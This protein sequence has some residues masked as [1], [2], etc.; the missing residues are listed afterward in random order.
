MTQPRVLLVGNIASAW[1]GTPTVCEGLGARLESQGWKVLLTSRRRPRLRRLAEML[2]TVWRERDEYDVAVVEVFSGPGFI[3]AES[4]CCL[5]SLLRKPHILWLHGG[6]LPEFA[7]R[8][9]RRASG[10]FRRATAIVAQSEYLAAVASA[11][12][13]KVH[14]ISNPLDLQLYPF[15]LRVSPEPRLVWIRSFHRTY[16]PSMA[17]RVVDRLRVDFPG[18]VLD[19]VGPDKGD[20]SLGEA[21]DLVEE[22]GLQRNVVFHSAV[23][24]TDVPLWLNR[25]DFF[26]NTTNIDNTPVSVQEAMACGL[27]VVSTGVGGVPYLA[28]DKVEAL[29]VPRD[30][31][32]AMA[33]A[34][35]MLLLHPDIAANI[36]SAARRRV[37]PMDWPRVMEAWESLLTFASHADTSGHR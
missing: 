25:A 15:T 18:V 4:V 34:V 29:L 19:M 5:L 13:E 3:W 6:G 32:V 30:D 12:R 33:D 14:L 8:W 10:L 24:K 28:R 1:G 16:N 9:R 11:H 17:V 37:E 7:S 23:P 20:G 22:L 31:G 27:C 36:S 21:R 35:H 26:L 2:A